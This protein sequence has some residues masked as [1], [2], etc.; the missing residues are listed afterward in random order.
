MVKRR[1]PRRRGYGAVLLHAWT[2][3]TDHELE[4]C[5]E[6]TR[7]E[8]T[9]DP[10]LGFFQMIPITHL[11]S[12]IRT[13]C[14]GLRRETDS[15]SLGESSKFCRNVWDWKYEHSHFGKIQPGTV[16]L[17]P[18]DLHRISAEQIWKIG[19]ILSAAQLN[20]FHC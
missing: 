13:H 20:I 10:L 18:F 9:Q 17:L 1:R 2:A 11:V 15:A 5:G 8:L 14:L 12:V 16:S 6:K 7:L 19:Q 3:V 4:P